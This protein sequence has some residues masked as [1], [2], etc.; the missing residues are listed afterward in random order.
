MVGLEDDPFLLG[1]GNFSGAFAVKL[2]GGFM[3]KLLWCELLLS[4]VDPCVAIYMIL[5]TL[6]KRFA[7]WV[8]PSIF[9]FHSPNSEGDSIC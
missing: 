9:S 4:S 6:L 5:K 1:A 3:V 2:R 7:F 8:F